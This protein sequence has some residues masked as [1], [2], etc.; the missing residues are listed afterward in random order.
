MSSPPR[1]RAQ[2]A[3]GNA[4]RLELDLKY[5]REKLALEKGQVRRPAPPTPPCVAPPRRV[6]PRSALC[7]AAR[8][9]GAVSSA[10]A[11]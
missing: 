6:E 7:R 5:A 1:E 10:A 9:D 8:P 2:E 3:I 4:A 11:R